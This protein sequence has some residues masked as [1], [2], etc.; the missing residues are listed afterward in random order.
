MCDAALETTGS[1]ARLR[2]LER[3]NLL[4][5]PLDD[6]VS[7]RLHPLLRDVLEEELE[8]QMPGK[9]KGVLRRASAWCAANGAIEEAIEYAHATGDLDLVAPLVVGH[10]WTLHW[11]GR[12]ATVDRWVRWF[13]EDG[14]R[15]R[16]PAIAVLAGFM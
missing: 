12:L 10:V 15:E 6:G 3:S 16:Y 5:H 8:V 4:I 13:D 9:A 2:Q 14:V 1:L 7:Y 11:S